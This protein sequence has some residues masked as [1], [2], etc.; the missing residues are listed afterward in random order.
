MTEQM[1][2]YIAQYGYLAILAMVFM[3]EVGIPSPIPNE[4]VLLVGGYLSFKG[5]LN[6]FLVVLS[7][8]V[9]DL[10]AS[11]I[12]FELF[13]FFGKSV[14]NRK[15]KWLP[16]SEVKLEKLRQKMET[17]GP[18]GMYIG[19]VTP[20]IKG[21]VSVLCGILRFPQKKYSIILVSTSVVW[22]LAYVGV[23]Y[24]SGPCFKNWS[25][26]NERH[27]FLLPVLLMLVVLLVKL[28]KKK[29]IV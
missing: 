17:S 5:I 18:F 27:L 7:A 4:F 29:S 12:L 10:L 2:P 13:Y 16:I 20:F 25:L 3:Q 11:F 8:I 24:L 21:Y 26:L 1:L 28:F 23:G 9:G 14:I 19:R 15:P 6:T 22:S